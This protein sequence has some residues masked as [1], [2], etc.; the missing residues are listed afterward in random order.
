MQQEEHK[1]RVCQLAQPEVTDTEL[2][3]QSDTQRNHD[4]Q[5]HYSRQQQERWA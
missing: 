1:L 4:L 3:V 5:D 2:P